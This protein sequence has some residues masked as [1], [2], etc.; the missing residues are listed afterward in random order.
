MLLTVL[1]VLHLQPR[2][3]RWIIRWQLLHPNT[4]SS[5][6]VLAPGAIPESGMVEIDL[7]RLGIQ[8]FAVALLTGLLVVTN[9]ANRT[10]DSPGARSGP[11]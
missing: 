4:T 9:G 2:L 5:S 6:L 7:T 1:G 11:C 8:V 10:G 3:R